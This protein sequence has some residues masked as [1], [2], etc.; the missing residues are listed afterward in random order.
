VASGSRSRADRATGLNREGHRQRGH[1]RRRGTVKWTL[2]VTPSNLKYQF[3]TDWM[4][5]FPDQNPCQDAKSLAGTLK[6]Q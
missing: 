2:I 4:V 6:K 1:L 3:D 5:Q